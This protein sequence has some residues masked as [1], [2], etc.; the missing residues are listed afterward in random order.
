MF[1]TSNLLNTRQMQQYI[2]LATLTACVN[3]A[4]RY[5]ELH[6]KFARDYY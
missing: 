6:I 1:Q 4:H 2:H 5:Y 3:I